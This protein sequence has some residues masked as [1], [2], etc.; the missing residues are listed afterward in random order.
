M[1][2]KSHHPCF[3]D[4]WQY[5]EYDFNMEFNTYFLN[6]QTKTDMSVSEVNEKRMNVFASSGT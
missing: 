1:K 3:L 2:Y 6:Q 4:T 5:F